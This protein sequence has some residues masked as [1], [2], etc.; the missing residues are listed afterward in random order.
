MK[1]NVKKNHARWMLFF[2]IHHW[3]TDIQTVLWGE[4]VEVRNHKTGIMSMR[5]VTTFFTNL[6]EI[7]NDEKE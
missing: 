1:I 4:N 7:F 5:N 3:F 6:D 2:F